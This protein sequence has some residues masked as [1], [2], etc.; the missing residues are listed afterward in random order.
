M[1]CCYLVAAGRLKCL[2]FGLNQTVWNWKRWWGTRRRQ[3]VGGETEQVLES[4]HF[5]FPPTAAQGTWGRAHGWVQRALCWPSPILQAVSTQGGE[6]PGAFS[7]SAHEG[8]QATG[9]PIVLTH[10]SSRVTWAEILLPACDYRVIVPLWLG[11]Y[12][13]TRSC[14]WYTVMV[15]SQPRAQMVVWLG[16]SDFWLRWPGPA[17]SLWQNRGAKVSGDRLKYQ[18]QFCF[19]LTVWLREV[20]VLLL[21]TCFLI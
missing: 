10:L 14:V 3:W 15:W 17:A 18:P 11:W 6:A 13:V 12:R 21:V 8:I 19:S 9:R 7:S 2:A 20:M 1:P 16:Q 5:V 4:D